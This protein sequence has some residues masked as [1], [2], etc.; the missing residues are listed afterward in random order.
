[1]KKCTMAVIALT[2]AQPALCAAPPELEAA[3]AKWAAP[4][5]TPRYQYSLVDLND[6]GKLDAIAFISDDNYCG[7]GGCWMVV[8]RGTSQGYALV[9]ATM[10]AQKPIFVLKDV[11][12]GWHSLAV[13]LGGFGREPGLALMR[14]DGMTYP[15]NAKLQNRIQLSAGMSQG[16]L[17]FQE[18]Q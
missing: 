1:M 8:L 3:V 13:G 18:A 16:A 12:F 6:D 11:Q 5:S 9:S 17:D 15:P 14:F 4:K 7:S 2:L 10:L